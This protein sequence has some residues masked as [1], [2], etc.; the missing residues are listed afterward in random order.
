MDNFDRYKQIKKAKKAQEKKLKDDYVNELQRNIEFNNKVSK[1]LLSLNEEKIR[2]HSI[3]HETEKL[4]HVKKLELMENELQINNDY[5]HKQSERLQHQ[6]E[7]NEIISQYKILR[8]KFEFEDRVSDLSNN[9]TLQ[10]IDLDHYLDLIQSHSERIQLIK[11]QGDIE[12]K[13]SGLRDEVISKLQEMEEFREQYAEREKQA[14]DVYKSILEKKQDLDHQ[15]IDVAKKSAMLDYT[16]ERLKVDS[17]QDN[18][19]EIH[20]HEMLK[21]ISDEEYNNG[22]HPKHYMI[23][24][25]RKEYGINGNLQQNKI[26]EEW[27]SSLDYSS[28]A[29]S[30]LGRKEPKFIERMIDDFLGE[31]LEWVKIKNEIQENINRKFGD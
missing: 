22:F 31:R 16:S 11:E 18:V 21:K 9:V 19:K 3:L 23:Y 17:L 27:V 13:K 4:S 5:Y 10:K 20:L 2:V 29:I 12:L 6:I 7:L 8:Q 15:Q 30:I 28:E 26:Y 24:K 1:E 14:L 25:L